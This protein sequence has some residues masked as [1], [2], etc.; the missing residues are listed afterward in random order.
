VSDYSHDTADDAFH[1]IQLSGKQ[2]VFLFMATTVVS[3][4]IFLCGV[5][6]GRGVRAEGATASPDAASA[7]AAATPPAS[8]PQ[9]ASETSVPVTEPPAPTTEPALSYPDRLQADKPVA[10]RLKS[11]G[12]A[13]R[14]ETAR[15]Q[16]QSESEPAPVAPPVSEPAPAPG[17]A[18][19]ASTPP[20]SGPPLAPAGG[21]P[22]SARSGTWVVQVQALRDRTEAAAIVRRLSSKG[23]PA[24][25]VSPDAKEP[26][27]MYRVHVGRYDDR[28]EAERIAERLKQEEKFSPWVRR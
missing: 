6:V 13:S 2:L 23:Y 9:I 20:V 3:V 5:L 10:E 22:T 12:E 19:A 1:E 14:P 4:V 25:V 7:E 27:G 18:A 11:A 24:F 17:L 16:R 21:V 26:S 8:A 15:P 28:A